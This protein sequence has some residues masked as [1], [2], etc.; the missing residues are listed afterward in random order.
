MTHFIFK[1]KTILIDLSNLD[2]NLEHQRIDLDRFWHHQHFWYQIIAIFPQT[3]KVMK[4]NFCLTRFF[5]VR[6]WILIV[7][8]SLKVFFIVSFHICQIVS[9]WPRPSMTFLTM[10]RW[11]D[12][13]LQLKLRNQELLWKKSKSIFLAKKSWNDCRSHF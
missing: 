3:K 2:R 9:S 6:N 13:F 5:C 10:D 8:L 4:R 12:A 7:F 1:V 11:R